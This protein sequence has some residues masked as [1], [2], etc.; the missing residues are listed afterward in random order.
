MIQ[1]PSDSGKHGVFEELHGFSG[2]KA[3]A[4]HLE[5]AVIHY[6]GS[7]FRDWLHCLTADLPEL[8]S[9]RKRC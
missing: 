6:H 3:L 2:G 1:I 4:E 7:P 9:G 8:T 5:H